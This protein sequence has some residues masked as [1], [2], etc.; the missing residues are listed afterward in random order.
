MIVNMQ[1][2][3]VT[4]I[5]ERPFLVMHTAQSMLKQISNVLCV[6]GGFQLF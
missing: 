2:V 6:S 5:A 1:L 4:E 3:G